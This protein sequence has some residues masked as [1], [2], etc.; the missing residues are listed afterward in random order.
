MSSKAKGRPRRS[1]QISAAD[2][3]YDD[4]V[5]VALEATH[6]DGARGDNG[7]RCRVSGDFSSKWYN[8]RRG[9]D[10]PELQSVM[11]SKWI[12]T[13][14]TL[15]EDWLVEKKPRQSGNTFDKYYRDPET[16]RK[17]RSL[18]DVERYLRQG[19]I[20][21]TSKSKGLNYHEKKSSYKKKIVSG[22]KMQDFEENRDNQYKLINVKPSSLLSASPFKLPDGWIVEEVPR[23]KGDRIDRY[24]C[25]PETGQR[26]RSLPSVQRHLAELEENSPLSAVDYG[27]Y[28]SWKRSISKKEQDSSFSN[29]PPN[30]IKWVIPSTPGET[31]N[32]F[33]GDELVPDSMKQLW[34]K[35]FMLVINNGQVL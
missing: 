14:F 30:K 26:F 35:R 23:K 12:T 22:G 10:S 15:P 34:G 31:W 6:K 25:E 4:L 18:K 16:G 1:G 3:E 21:T 9:M 17:F 32:A 13:K 29:P 7:C 5:P 2:D 28:G 24:Y 20:P 27:S 33:A 19:F 11:E 8:R